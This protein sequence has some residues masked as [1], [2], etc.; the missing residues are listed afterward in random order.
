[1]ESK[2]VLIVDDDEELCELLRIAF[3]AKAYEVFTA[4]D[5]EAG[6]TMARK[7]KPSA[8]I[9]DIKMPRLNGYEFLSQ[10]RRDSRIASIPVIILTSVTESSSRSDEEWARSMEVQDF[11]S[12]PIEPF[13][14]V[15]RV[16]RVVASP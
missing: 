3:E 6:L 5:G 10:L 12:K 14:L 7:R 2:R 9:L 11:V 13:Q 4:L 16:E 15:E 1:M 8:I